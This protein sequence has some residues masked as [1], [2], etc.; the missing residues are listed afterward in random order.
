MQKNVHCFIVS[1]GK[2]ILDTVRLC[3]CVYS[4]VI[5]VIPYLPTALYID[6]VNFLQPCSEHSGVGYVWV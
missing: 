5:K 6:F 4:Q 2:E 1:R 3:V